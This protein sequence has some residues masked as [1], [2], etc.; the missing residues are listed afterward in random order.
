MVFNFND[1]NHFNGYI[2][3]GGKKQHE[4]LRLIC[5]INPS[6]K[7]IKFKGDVT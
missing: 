4:L 5:E 1:Q 2:L 7:E 3:Q 6:T